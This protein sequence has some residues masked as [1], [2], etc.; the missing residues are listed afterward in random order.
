M[1][2]TTTQNTFVNEAD[3]VIIY[4]D[5]ANNVIH[6]MLDFGDVEQATTDA[7]KEQFELVKPK[8]GHWHADP[9]EDYYQGIDV[10]VVIRRKADGRLFGFSYW[11]AISKHAEPYFEPNGDQH[12][13]EFEPPA[14]F[15]WDNGYFPHP[16][17]FVPV[18]PFTITGYAPVKA[19]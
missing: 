18:E 15:D 11:T 14:D 6:D 16:F 3:R 8:Q 19:A 17:V 1:T 13:L 12:G 10:M 2:E 7:F 9:E 4:D 5:L